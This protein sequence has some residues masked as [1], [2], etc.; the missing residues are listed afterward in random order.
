MRTV[1]ALA[2]LWLAVGSSS[3][4]PA[5]QFGTGAYVSPNGAI[6]TAAHVVKGCEHVTVID[7][8]DA[9]YRGG[10]QHHSQ[11][12]DVAVVSG[13]PP[14]TVDGA[15]LRVATQ[16]DSGPLLTT[17]EAFL[18]LNETADVKPGDHV[19][20]AGFS[21]EKVQSARD[22][23]LKNSYTLR[24]GRV[25]VAKPQNQGENSF[26]LS[27]LI[28]L[29]NSGAAV[30]DSHGSLVGVVWGASP[31]RSFGT[32]THLPEVLQALFRARVDVR[33][34]Q[35]RERASGPMEPLSKEFAMRRAAAWANAA[36]VGVVCEP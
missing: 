6:V 22:M 32:A 26:R 31:D 5:A 7:P 9:K 25:L 29:G 35:I 1:A 27:S 28:T 4:V 21:S 13:R 17:A 12:H 23:D 16:A 8:G 3:P 36:I 19:L 2:L 15:A 34:Y 24:P 33:G 30:L 10:V 14:R 18:G 20:V 11:E